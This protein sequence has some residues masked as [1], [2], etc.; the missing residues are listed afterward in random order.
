MTKKQVACELREKLESHRTQSGIFNL[1]LSRIEIDSL[2][3]ALL[4]W[5]MEIIEAARVDER[6]SCGELP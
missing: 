1:P 6:I 2:V 5:I 3:P 4:P